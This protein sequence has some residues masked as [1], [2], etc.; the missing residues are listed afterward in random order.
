MPCKNPLHLDQ[1]RNVNMKYTRRR[2]KDYT[3]RFM[4]SLSLLPS[5]FGFCFLL[6]SH[7]HWETTRFGR[8]VSEIGGGW[9]GKVVVL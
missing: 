7:E 2:E 6:F 5:S 4:V 8:E 9:R 3:G 1:S